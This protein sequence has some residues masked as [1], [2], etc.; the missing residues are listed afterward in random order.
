MSNSNVI[1]L[2]TQ[3]EI[4]ERVLAL[5]LAG[6]G[7]TRIARE[8]KLRGTKEVIEALERALPTVD[9]SYRSRILREE[10]ARL[11]QLQ[12]WWHDAARTSA[13]AAAILLKIAE[14]R[15]MMLGLE[16]QHIRMDPVQIVSGNQPQEGSTAALLAEMD[17]ICAE[18]RL[19]GIEIEASV[20][21]PVDGG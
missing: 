7:T 13:P 18:R 11:D 4:D 12:S 14:R 10:L 16:P 19:K 1:E 3:S 17:R 21:A 15:S 2:T 20:E 5:R 9:A 6:I 8:L